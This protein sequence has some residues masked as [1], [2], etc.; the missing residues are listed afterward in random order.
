MS[1]GA[2]GGLRDVVSTLDE[3]SPWEA[4]SAAASAS[5]GLRVV[6]SK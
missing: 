5:S 6:E 3:L 2:L 4:S 1:S